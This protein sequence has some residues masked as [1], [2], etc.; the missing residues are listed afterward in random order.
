M[1]SHC[2]RCCQTC[3]FLGRRM[4]AANAP[5]TAG[6]IYEALS[7][8]RER[9]QL[10]SVDDPNHFNGPTEPACILSKYQIH[11]EYAVERD[12]RPPGSGQ[13]RDAIL[14]VITAPRDCKEWT[15]YRPGLSP[16]ESV[17]IRFFESMERSRRRFERN[18]LK[19]SQ[20]F[21]QRLVAGVEADN[22][23]WDNKQRAR[24]LTIA[25]VALIIALLALPN[26]PWW[27][28][29]GRQPPSS[30]L[31]TPE[32]ERPTKSEPG[33]GKVPPP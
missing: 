22:R 20:A 1:D 12:K 2:P 10:F 19:E 32:T 33:R 11:D 17:A 29:W 6:K 5:Y 13:E 16:K 14:R 15:R 3:A 31:L 24:D 7:P 4:T 9:G 23:K 28:F 25:L 8:Q 27:K 18:L 21:D 30:E 26:D